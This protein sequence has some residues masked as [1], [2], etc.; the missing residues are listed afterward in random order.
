[1]Y[2]IWSQNFQ[3][4]GCWLGAH[5]F[6]QWQIHPCW[7]P[8]NRCLTRFHALNSDRFSQE[9]LRRLLLNQSKHLILCEI[10]YGKVAQRVHWRKDSCVYNLTFIVQKMRELGSMICKVTRSLLLPFPFSQILSGQQVRFI[11]YSSHMSPQ[12]FLVLFFLSSWTLK[13]SLRS[14]TMSY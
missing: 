5:S 1:M 12:S 14:D 6:S 11:E 3:N 2:H 13:S 8:A 9:K 10:Y 4:I 7:T